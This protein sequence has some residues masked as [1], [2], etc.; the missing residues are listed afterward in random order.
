MC[1]ILREAFDKDTGFSLYNKLEMDTRDDLKINNK[2]TTDWEEE[3]RKLWNATEG[4]QGK[5]VREETNTSGLAAKSIMNQEYQVQ[6]SKRPKRERSLVLAEYTV[7]SRNM[8]VLLQKS[9]LNHF[10]PTY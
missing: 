6:L 8:V 1:G 5:L 10:V 9:L 2:A 3:H 7:S 4:L